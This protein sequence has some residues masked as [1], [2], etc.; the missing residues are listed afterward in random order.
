MG[1][2][3]D[4][5]LMPF[6]AKVFRKFIFSH[7]MNEEMFMDLARRLS[8]N[9][10]PFSNAGISTWYY[11]PR[12]RK[13]DIA[14]GVID[15]SDG[16]RYGIV[17]DIRTDKEGTQWIYDFYFKAEFSQD[18][19]LIHGEAMISEEYILGHQAIHVGATIGEINLTI[20]REVPY[21]EAIFIARLPKWDLPES[22]GF[23]RNAA[24]VAD[25]IRNWMRK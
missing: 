1:K 9:N 23:L 7:N 11:W 24:T 8:G 19:E 14:I 20:E 6:G 17:A 18:G 21:P 25:R 15:S 22:Y 12:G 10:G 4:R 16:K 13:G 5:T 3:K 2:K